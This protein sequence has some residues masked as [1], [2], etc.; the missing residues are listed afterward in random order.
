VLREHVSD[1][2]E[3]D[4]D[5]PYMLLVCDVHPG[6]GGRSTSRRGGLDKLKLVR[7]TLR[8]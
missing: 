3:M 4:R 5:S 2:Y 1:F 8:R 7:S 6:S